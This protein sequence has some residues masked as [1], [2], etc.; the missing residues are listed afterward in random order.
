MTLVL[1]GLW[2]GSGAPARVFAE[3][4]PPGPERGPGE[5]VLHVEVRGSSPVRVY[6]WTPAGSAWEP[7][8]TA[9]CG[10]RVSREGIWF[11]AGERLTPS[12]GLLLP[13]DAEEV[14][15][16]V[17]PRS[18]LRANLGLVGASVGGAAVMA[19]VAVL[20]LYRPEAC[21]EQ[22]GAGTDPCGNLVRLGVPLLVVGAA[23]FAGGMVLAS[24][25]A[26]RVAV[27]RGRPSARTGRLSLTAAGLAF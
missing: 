20:A 3:P 15:L 27:Y 24:T 7:V 23:L 22:P 14:T 25:A 5:T 11:V 10:Q 8:C 18:I 4:S 16:R 13:A 1:A 17:E 2:I 12:R 19:G 9:P 21:A 26:T 6:R